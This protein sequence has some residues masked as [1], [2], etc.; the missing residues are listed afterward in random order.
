[1]KEVTTIINVEIS[2]INI[3]DD[4]AVLPDKDTIAEIYKKALPNVDKIEVKNVKHFELK[5]KE[6]KDV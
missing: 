6:R 2:F 4:D 5:M 1:M 3:V